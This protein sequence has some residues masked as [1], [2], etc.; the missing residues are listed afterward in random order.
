MTS[1]VLSACVF[2]LM[3]FAL[4]TATGRRLL[5]A[6][7]LQNLPEGP[8]LPLSEK[9]LILG[10]EV[11]DESSDEVVESDGQEER[12]IFGSPSEIDPA[13]RSAGN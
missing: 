11:F 4:P 12:D 1:S 3:C 2:S 13:T 10:E 7:S 9:T 6:P 5:Q 8:G